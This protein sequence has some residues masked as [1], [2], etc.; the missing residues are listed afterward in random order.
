[1]VE[2]IEPKPDIPANVSE[3]MGQLVPPEMARLMYSFEQGTAAFCKLKCGLYLGVHM[4]QLSHMEGIDKEGK[5]SL[6]RKL[7]ES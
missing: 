4:D 2:R 6:C 1:M 7:V 3:A 5:W